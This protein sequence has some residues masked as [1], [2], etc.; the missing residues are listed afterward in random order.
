MILKNE[1]LKPDSSQEPGLILHFHSSEVAYLISYREHEKVQWLASGF[2]LVTIPLLSASSFH[3]SPAVSEGEILYCFPPV[4]V[5]Q[6]LSLPQ[7]A[8]YPIECDL[9]EESED[10]TLMRIPCYKLCEC[11]HSPKTEQ[12]IVSSP[13]SLIQLE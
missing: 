4:I 2:L 12:T 13:I 3:P 5:T 6:S 11:Q 1:S 9:L 10:C 8:L 7:M